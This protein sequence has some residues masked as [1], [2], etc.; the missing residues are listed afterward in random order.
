MILDNIKHRDC[1][2]V[3]ITSSNNGGKYSL[4]FKALEVK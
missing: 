3:V 4:F 1:M 2:G